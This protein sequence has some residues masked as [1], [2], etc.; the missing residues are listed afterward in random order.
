MEREGDR[1]R[2]RMEDMDRGRVGD[3]ERNDLNSFSPCLLVSRSP[4]LLVLPQG[5]LSGSHERNVTFRHHSYRRERAT[6]IIIAGEKKIRR[7]FRWR[8]GNSPVAFII[9]GGLIQISSDKGAARRRF[10]SRR[11]QTVAR[12][13]QWRSLSNH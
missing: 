7:R 2:G 9:H 5:A 11:R 8:R 10:F 3:K 13:A 6:K 4:P 12:L 1:E